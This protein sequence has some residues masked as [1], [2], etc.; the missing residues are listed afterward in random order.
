MFAKYCSSGCRHGNQLDICSHL[1]W[2]VTQNNSSTSTVLVMLIQL[3]SQMPHEP[4]VIVDN[5][6]LT[7]SH[8]GSELERW[9]KTK[10]TL[11]GCHKSVKQC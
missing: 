3:C 4:T 1:F 6:I 5:S 9:N 10:D 8:K 2:D 7:A 11:K